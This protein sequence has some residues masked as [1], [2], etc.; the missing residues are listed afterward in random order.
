MSSLK[1]Y[2]PLKYSLTGHVMP[3]VPPQLGQFS[4][5]DP[6]AEL[7]MRPFEVDTEEETSLLSA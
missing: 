1:L 2:S 5:L 3:M 7:R 4:I 6:G